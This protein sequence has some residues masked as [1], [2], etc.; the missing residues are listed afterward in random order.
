MR[1]DFW[2]KWALDDG[3]LM[4][5]LIG[6]VMFGGGAVLG[7]T[8]LANLTSPDWFD[9]HIEVPIHRVGEDPIISYQRTI[10]Q[11]MQGRWTVEVLQNRDGQWV[12]VCQGD[13]LAPYAITEAGEVTMRLS[14]YAGVDMAE[15]ITEPG[16][17]RLITAWSMTRA[18]GNT[19]RIFWDESNVFEVTD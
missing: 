11:N 2:H 4:L 18:E 16:L 5:A 17:Y 13:G 10:T 12:E 9:A 14:T 1:L 3:N 6:S 7:A 19:P 15:C 8:V